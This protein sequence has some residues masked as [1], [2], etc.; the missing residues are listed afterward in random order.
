[1]NTSYKAWVECM[2]VSDDAV[3]QILPEGVC[4]DSLF[5]QLAISYARI[6]QFQFENYRVRI[7]SD[8]QTME[9]SKMG[10]QCEWFY[11]ELKDFYNQR[12]LKAFGVSGNM[13]FETNG[14][15]FFDGWKGRSTIRIYEDCICI[16][17]P[18]M[19]GRRL[20]FVFINGMK[21][22]DYAVSL[23]LSSG[24]IY[25][26][27]MMGRDFDPFVQEVMTHIRAQKEENI[28]FIQKLDDTIG[29][30]EAT[31]LSSVFS[32][33]ILISIRQLLQTSLK[34][35]QCIRSKIMKSKIRYS[36]KQMEAL[37]DSEKM[38]I[39]I[40]EIPEEQLANQ[41]A[42]IQE[43]NPEFSIE[44]QEALRWSLWAA[45]PS[46]N[47]KKAIVEFCIPMEATATY[48]FQIESSWEEFIS[49]LNLGMEATD[50]A[51]ELLTL[52]ENEL[53]FESN[54]LSFMLIQRTTSIQSL[55]RQYFG[56]IIHRSEE[57]W[58]KELERILN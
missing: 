4:I 56:R 14:F 24:E 49:D 41:L 22:E 18:N 55:R 8:I 9:C 27:S 34:L 21:R 50:W 15:C 16:L 46:K 2:E 45:A 39:G 57:Q 42:K 40:K 20:P 32:E 17:P 7:E 37:C 5:S 44:D 3:I 13:E 12:V 10:Q 47:E 28:K 38:C 54:D 30:M 19:Y 52:P 1:M 11:N 48:V 35:E 26:F 29:L 23:R 53:M 25:Q 6:N 33:G 31:K 51:R 58:K 36:V 43:T